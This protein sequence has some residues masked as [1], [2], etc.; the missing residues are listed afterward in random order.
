[1]A[2]DS[3]IEFNKNYRSTIDIV[4][5]CLTTIFACTWISVHPNI[6]SPHSTHWQRL[7]QR[8]V[9][10]A[11]ALICPELML[12]WAYRQWVG[13]RRISGILGSKCTI[14]HAHFLQMGGVV[15]DYEGEHR[16]L[17]LMKILEDWPVDVYE[18]SRENGL[19]PPLELTDE[20]RRRPLPYSA[21]RSILEEMP[22]TVD[23]ISD[24]S[25]GD[26]LAKSFVVIQTTWFIVQCIA[27]AIEKLDVTELEI[28]TLAYA[29]LNGVVYYLWW[30]KPLDVQRP[31]VISIDPSNYPGHPP[32]PSH[33]EY[34]RTL[35]PWYK[36]EWLELD[37]P[38]SNLRVASPEDGN[39]LKALLN[40]IRTSIR[41]LAQ[42][43]ADMSYSSVILD[44][45][46][47]HLP[48]YYAFPA[49]DKALFSVLIGTPLL[50]SGFGAIHC[51]A[52]NFNFHSR[53]VQIAW[54]ICGLYVAVSP[55]IFLISP[56]IGRLYL[57]ICGPAKAR[58]HYQRN[59]KVA[60][61]LAFLARCSAL[62]Y[63]PARIVLVILAL[64]GL[65]Y[66][67]DKGHETVEWSN[68]IPHV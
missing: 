8:L 42:E 57:T 29:A 32:E 52:W 51:I 54:R 4:W 60:T 46:V 10:F 64:R 65:G 50:A 28:V 67:T 38:P 31:E 21:A 11:W 27:R 45:R 15:F 22:I 25:K 61:G 17:D 47:P 9:L 40:L 6:L 36:E 5:M 63:I 23:H 33:L 43:I 30:G 12:M 35:M 44:D 53:Q 14:T 48:R 39:V 34:Y 41:K 68:F 19:L 66:L 55:L 24:K 37:L 7:R 49:D 62:L 56:C 1:M 3:S 26:E 59:L 13:A 18:S 58:A 2:P 16:C 20:Q